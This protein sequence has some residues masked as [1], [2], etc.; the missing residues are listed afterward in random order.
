MPVMD[1]FEAS[2]KIREF[3]KNSDLPTAFIIALTAHALEEHREAVIASGMNYFLS[4]PMSLDRLSNTLKQLGLTH[5]ER[6]L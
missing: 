6:S 5:T 4:K 2:K 1:G 3:E